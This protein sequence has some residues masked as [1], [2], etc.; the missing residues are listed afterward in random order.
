[1]RGIGASGGSI[2]VAVGKDQETSLP[3]MSG[4]D[5]DVVGISL[6]DLPPCRNGQR[7]SAIFNNGAIV[8][9]V[10]MQRHVQVGTVALRRGGEGGGKG[11][12]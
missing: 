3:R 2:D 8:D 10:T 7:L 9:F 5:A 6:G 1:M 12:G 11:G 4:T